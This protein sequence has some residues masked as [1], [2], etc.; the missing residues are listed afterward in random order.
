MCMELE[1]GIKGNRVTILPLRIED[2]Y[3]M[4]NWGKHENPLLED[5]NFPYVDEEEIVEWYESKTFGKSKKYFSVYNEYGKLIGYLG[6]KH[7]KRL[8]KE[9]TLGIVFD[10]NYM[11]KGYGTEAIKAFLK[12]FFDDLKMNVLYLEVAGFNKRAIQCYKK[13]GFEKVSKYL[14]RYP[15]QSIDTNNPYFV[16]EI[17]SFVFRHGRIYNYIYKMK[18]DRKIFTKMEAEIEK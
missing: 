9:A 16:E 1:R 6:I 18:I 17:D 5:Y 3:L 10:P 4:M 13:C 8:K 11:N 15:D 2:V 12:Y 14:N 7:I